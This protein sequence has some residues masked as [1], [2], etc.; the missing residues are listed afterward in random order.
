MWLVN[1]FWVFVGM[2]LMLVMCTVKGVHT[3]Y[4]GVIQAYLNLHLFHAHEAATVQ[5]M[6]NRVGLP[7]TLTDT[8]Q[9]SIV[10]STVQHGLWWFAN[11]CV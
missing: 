11:L 6:A 7:I 5:R 1:A 10:Q 2:M 3:P 9:Q 8:Q 4:L